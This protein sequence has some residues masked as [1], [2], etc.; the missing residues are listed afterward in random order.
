M[1]NRKGFTLIELMIVV[2]IVGILAA[3]A[4]PMYNVQR[5]KAKLTEGTRA[6]SS[7]AS[8]VGEYYQDHDNNWPPDL[9]GVSAIDNTLGVA[10]ATNRYISNIAVA[11]ANGAITVTFKGTN[12]TGVDGQAVILT[13]APQAGGAIAWGWTGDGT[14]PDKYVPNE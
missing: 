7:V 6:A 5:V 8:A 4:I 1:K 9:S 10:F 13:P 3:I 14:I 11:N 2:A 12:T